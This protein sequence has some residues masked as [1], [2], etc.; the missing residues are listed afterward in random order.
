[1]NEESLFVKALVL[2]TVSDRQG[3]LEKAC[4]GNVALRQRVERLLAAHMETLGILD[5]AAKRPGLTEVGAGSA[6]GVAP[7]GECVGTVVA[8]RYRLL[9][10]IGAGG[11]GTVWKAEQTQP[12]RRMV[13]LKLI[14]AGMDS[15]SSNSRMQK[16][17]WSSGTC[18]I[19]WNRIS[20][21][22]GQTSGDRSC[23][24]HLKSGTGL[25]RSHMPRSWPNKGKIC[26]RAK[27]TQE[28]NR[29]CGIRILQSCSLAGDWRWVTPRI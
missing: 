23:W 18:V 3:F 6:P 27:G 26:C 14:K 22:I 10:E 1:M 13:A 5:Q 4:A 28:P 17:V 21:S 12:V 20:S 7:G 24:R 8:G 11:M 9:E 15:R 2:P 19:A 25:T 29:S 16:L